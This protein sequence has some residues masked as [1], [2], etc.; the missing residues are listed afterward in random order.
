M[1]GRV[2]ILD[3]SGGRKEGRKKERKKE[4]DGLE[5]AEIKERGKK[6]NEFIVLVIFTIIAHEIIVLQC[7]AGG[8]SPR[9]GE[10]TR[11]L[12]SE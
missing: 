6:R 12:Q 10:N 2:I 5:T 9:Y 8:L 3:K 7:A 4:E 11:C 1:S